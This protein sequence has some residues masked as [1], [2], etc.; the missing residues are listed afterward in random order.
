[1]ALPSEEI[2]KIKEKN[3]MEQVSLYRQLKAQLIDKFETYRAQGNESMANIISKS[4]K[5]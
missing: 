3:V 5:E 1:M 4:L 2:D